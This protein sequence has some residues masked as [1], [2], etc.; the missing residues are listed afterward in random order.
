MA[1]I[2]F[3]GIAVTEM[4]GKLGNEIF[5]RNAQG[6]YVKSFVIPT[7]TI[8]ALRTA[9]RENFASA[10]SLWSIV[11][12]S[13]LVTW[14]ELQSRLF[15][16]SKVSQRYR[17]NSRSVFISSNYNLLCAGQLPVMVAD[18]LSKLEQIL[19]FSIVE[20]K[21]ANFRLS[22]EFVG[23]GSI[24]PLNHVLVVSAS[25]SVSSGIK[26]KKNGLVVVSV[27]DELSDASDFDVIADYSSVYGS[28]VSGKN[29]FLSFHLV[30]VLNGLSSVRHFGFSVVS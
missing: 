13:Q 30:N 12:E 18:A 29:I 2:I 9:A 5:S 6:A 26:S 23:N 3:S 4:R 7:N 17:L 28:P 27:L 25:A 19:S 8:T 21:S 10:V 24:V 16:S 11:D 1:K 14:Q 15:R 20:L 22:V